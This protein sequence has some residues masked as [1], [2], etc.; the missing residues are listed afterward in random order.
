MSNNQLCEEEILA[1]RKMNQQFTERSGFKQKLALAHGLQMI[2]D[3]EEMFGNSV[4]ISPCLGVLDLQLDEEPVDVLV[5]R[6][7]LVCSHHCMRNLIHHRLHS[8]G[9]RRPG[10]DSSG[11]QQHKRAYLRAYRIRIHTCCGSDNHS[12]V[13]QR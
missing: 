6:S 3:S 2:L 10:C 11:A 1:I 7:V 12:H 5:R 8:L 9:T 4:H 13:H